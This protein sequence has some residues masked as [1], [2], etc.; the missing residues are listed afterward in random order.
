MNT[1]SEFKIIFLHLNDLYPE[2]FS[3]VKKIVIICI[4]C[5]RINKAMLSII[6]LNQIYLMW[7]I[8]FMYF[9]S[10]HERNRKVQ[11]DDTTTSE[12]KIEPQEQTLFI[13]KYDFVQRDI[14]RDML[15]MKCYI[16]KAS[17]AC[18][19]DKFKKSKR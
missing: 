19:I 15:L 18:F 6:I 4:I 2:M 8:C 10:Y 12:G 9:L 13:Q 14:S 1:K 3:F 16:F 11:K 5:L 17:S 7:N